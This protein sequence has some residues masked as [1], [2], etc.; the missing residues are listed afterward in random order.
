MGKCTRALVILV[1]AASTPA[2]INQ[3]ARL[4]RRQPDVRSAEYLEARVPGITEDG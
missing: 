4:F 1:A 2:V 3:P